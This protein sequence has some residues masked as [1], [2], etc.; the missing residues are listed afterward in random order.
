MVP[1]DSSLT[2]I[3]R[4]KSEASRPALIQLADPT[5]ATAQDALSHAHTRAIFRAHWWFTDIQ[6]SKA[7]KDI[8]WA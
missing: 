2:V 3:F 7:T 8:N 4:P 1:F 5:A 6:E